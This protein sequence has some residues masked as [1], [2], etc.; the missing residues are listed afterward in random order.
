MTEILENFRNRIFYHGTSGENAKSIKEEGFKTQFFFD[1]EGDQEFWGDSHWCNYGGNL[2]N[3]L[4]FTCNWRAALWFG[5]ALLRVE[6]RPGTR[7]LLTSVEPD[8]KVINYLKKEFS[9]EILTKS[10]FKVIPKNKRLKLN[11]LVNLFRYCYWQVWEKPIMRHEDDGGFEFRPWKRRRIVCDDLLHKF[12]SILIRYGFHG[13]GNPEDDNG[14]VI[15][16]AD[17]IKN[18]EHLFTISRERHLQDWDSW[19]KMELDKLVKEFGE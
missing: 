16:S 15:F 5:E 18:T 14:I 17:R 8:Y 2:G 10:P 11:E 6:L 3:G 7:L 12:R 1:N 9:K 4:Y 13:F 19:D